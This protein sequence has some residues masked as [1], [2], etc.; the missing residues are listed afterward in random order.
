MNNNNSN[1]KQKKNE[2]MTHNVFEKSDKIQYYIITIY[3]KNKL[4][5]IMAMT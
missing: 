5:L 4:K 2:R 3:I 1:Q